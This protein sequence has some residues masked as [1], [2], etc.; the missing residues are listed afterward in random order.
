MKILK[1]NIIKIVLLS[2]IFP[3]V[4]VVMGNFIHVK[5]VGSLMQGMGDLVV[6]LVAY[7]LNQRYFRQKIAWFNSHQVAAQLYTALPAIIIVA[8]LDSPVLMATDFQIKWQVIIV[9][10]LV[11]L[12]EEFIFRGILVKLFL[13]VLNG[14]ALGSVVGS[15]IIFGLIHFMN[16]RSLPF[17]YVSAQVIFAAAIGIIFGAIYIKTN[18]LLIVIL[19]HALRDMFPM[20]SSK[21]MAQAATTSFS[22]A[23][24]YVMIIFL[25][26]AVT[27]AYTQLRDFTVKKDEI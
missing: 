10:L 25:F 18:N 17:G 27:I 3:V 7:F 12:A 11:G 23:T 5:S 19:L 1:N 4:L 16:L 9:C 15:G 21:M 8:F 6:F 14:D 26:I 22:M 2:I 20:F 13:K 24:L